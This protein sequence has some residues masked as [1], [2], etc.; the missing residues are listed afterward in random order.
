MFKVY[1]FKKDG[2]GAALQFKISTDKK[3]LPCVFAEA[4]KQIEGTGVQDGRGKWDEKIIMK[5]GITDLG[6]LLLVL[7]GIKNSKDIIHKKD[8][9]STTTLTINKNTAEG[10]TGYYVKMS[11]KS[12]TVIR[13]QVALPVTDGE[14]ECLRIL[15]M[16]V[17]KDIIRCE[18]NVKKDEKDQPEEIVETQETG[19]KI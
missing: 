1:K 10:Y 11:G 14:A 19:E 16:E 15:A 8:E 3:G 17:V 4:A 7:N 5:L 13:P 12:D 18:Y 2:N 6:E 9:K